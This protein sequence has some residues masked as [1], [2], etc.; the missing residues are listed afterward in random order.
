MKKTPTMALIFGIEG[1]KTS[2]EVTTPRDL[3]FNVGLKLTSNK[4]SQILYHYDE[5]ILSHDPTIR[6]GILMPG[7]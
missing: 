7:L 4:L 3:Q 1:N 2:Q 6:T 5:P